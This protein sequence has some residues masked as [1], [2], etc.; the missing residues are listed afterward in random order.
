[1]IEN[2]PKHGNIIQGLLGYRRRL[3]HSKVFVWRCA[4]PSYTRIGAVGISSGIDK[5]PEEN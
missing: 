4:S 2:V 1:M 3:L 5:I